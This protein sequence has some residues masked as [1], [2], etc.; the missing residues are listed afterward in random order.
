MEET[1]N[2]IATIIEEES[3]QI[4][5]VP[6][7]FKVSLPEEQVSAIIALKHILEGEELLI[8]YVS[9]ES[10]ID[11]NL[12]PFIIELFIIPHKPDIILKV[13]D[14]DNE[15]YNMYKLERSEVDA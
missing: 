8:N 9:I 14:E 11:F 1:I 7:M 5:G 13:L 3:Y 6:T 10:E 2:F 4:E 15:L 12:D